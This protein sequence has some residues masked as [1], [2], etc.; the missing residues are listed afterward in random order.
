[1]KKYSDYLAAKEA[2][3]EKDIDWDVFVKEQS[4]SCPCESCDTYRLLIDDM[5]KWMSIGSFAKNTPQKVINEFKATMKKA[6]AVKRQN[7]VDWRDE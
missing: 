6:N 3:R 7:S 4:E 1:M 2:E 5:T